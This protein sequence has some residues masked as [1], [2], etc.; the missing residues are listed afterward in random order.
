MTERF[1]F[2]ERKIMRL[3][4]LWLFLLFSLPLAAAD[5]VTRL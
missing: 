5:D 4:S 2:R 1:I 3:R